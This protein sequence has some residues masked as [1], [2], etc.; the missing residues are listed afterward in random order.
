MGDRASEVK[1]L[2]LVREE[3]EKQL[4]AGSWLWAE[5]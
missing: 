3:E 5:S 4:R 1:W 2:F